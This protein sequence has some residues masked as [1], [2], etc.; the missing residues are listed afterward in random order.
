[1]VRRSFR[2]GLRL[3]LLI[4]ALVAIVK[5]VQ[6]RRAVEEPPAHVTPP[7]PWPPRPAATPTPTPTPAAVPAA[8]V[9]MAGAPV[10]EAPPVTDEP[11]APVPEAGPGGGVVEPQPRRERP[12]KA[13]PTKATKATKKAAKKAAPADD[14]LWVEPSGTTCPPSHPIKA[15]L[16]SKLFHLPGMLAYERTKPDRCYAT[17]DGAVADGLTKARR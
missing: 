16:A 12:L 10:V 15:K 2:R 9:A 5:V 14:R 13:P 7:A 11:P 6:S 8:D 17:E 3:G 4:G 1:M